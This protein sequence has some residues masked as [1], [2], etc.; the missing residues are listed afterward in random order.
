MKQGQ[1][2]HNNNNRQQ[3]RGRGNQRSGGGGG[4]RPGGGG[5]NPVNRVYESN[6]PDLKVRGNAQTI[7]EKY[8]QLARDAHTAG[9]PVMAESYYQHAEH[10]LRIL[11]AAQ[12]FN[13]QNAPQQSER[14][15]ADEGYEDE[16]D[17]TETERGP[18]SQQNN[19]GNDDDQGGQQPDLPDS[20]MFTAPPPRENRDRDRDRDRD[21][22]REPRDQ[23]REPRE[24]REP[25]D[26][27]REPRENREPR[28]DRPPRRFEDQRRPPRE[29]REPRMSDEQP[30]VGDEGWTGPQPS[31]LKRPVAAL[32][33]LAPITPVT[34]APAPVAAPQP[35]IEPQV[36]EAAAPSGDA[37]PAPRVRRAYVRKTPVEPTDTGE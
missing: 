25:R 36:M 12:A 22:N 23:N 16:I 1:H 19:Q 27:N 4:N 18:Y 2:R 3:Q 21:Y 6:G 35:V 9:D 10:Y 33:P 30:V 20:P 8:Q 24:A 26:Q 34:P 5:G 7:A 13:Q 32:A 37:A 15:A 29:F 17:T 31:F 11:A 14:R 28:G